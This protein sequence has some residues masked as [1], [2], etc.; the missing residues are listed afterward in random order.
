[1]N[2]AELIDALKS[3]ETVVVTYRVGIQKRT[4]SSYIVIAAQHRRLP[5]GNIVE[6]A[7]VKDTVANSAMVVLAKDIE[8]MGAIT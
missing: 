6:C 8:K 7:E 2:Y 5:N 3:G 1:M 4:N